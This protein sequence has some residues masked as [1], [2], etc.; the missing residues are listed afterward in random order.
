MI[1]LTFRHRPSKVLR[2]DTI[3]HLNTPLYEEDKPAVIKAVMAELHLGTSMYTPY[4]IFRLHET[5]EYGTLVRTNDKGEVESS[6]I[7]A[8]RAKLLPR[9]VLK[10]FVTDLLS[11]IFR[12]GAVKI[13]E[14]H[15]R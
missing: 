9:R 3:L 13:D 15:K 5:G 11:P 8:E 10:Q 1:K 6:L 7:E 14:L 2:K 4:G 12:E